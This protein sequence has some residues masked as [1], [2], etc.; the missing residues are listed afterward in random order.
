MLEGLDI[1]RA[2]KRNSLFDINGVMVQSRTDLADFQKV[3]AIDHEPVDTCVDAVRALKPTGII[4]VNTVPKLF[5]QPVIEAMSEIN[6][7]PII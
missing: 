6:Q 4:G 2:R 3:F 1:G 5:S 7:R